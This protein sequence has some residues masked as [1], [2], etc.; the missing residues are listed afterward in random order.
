MTAYLTGKNKVK[1]S[2]YRKF[3]YH[4]TSSWVLSLLDIALCRCFSIVC[5]FCFSHPVFSFYL[6]M[7][8][9]LF[10]Y[11]PLALFASLWFLF[12]AFLTLSITDCN[13]HPFSFNHT[14]VV[15]SLLRLFSVTDHVWYVSVGS[16]HYIDQMVSSLAY[17]AFVSFA[18]FLYIFRSSSILP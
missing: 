1:L 13:V 8:F 2:A 6:Y 16:M 9:H 4:F 14:C 18:E 17:L 15:F 3:S 11:L 10:C 12:N 5:V 7:S